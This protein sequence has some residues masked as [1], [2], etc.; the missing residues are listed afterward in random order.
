MLSEAQNT[1][2]PQDLTLLLE[3]WRAGNPSALEQLTPLVY[4]ELHQIAA[5]FLAG[6]RPAHVLQPTALINE[7]FLRLLSWHPDS[8]KSR[9]H[10]YGVSAQLMR[11]VLVQYA[12]HEKAEKRGGRA[13]L[14]T[15]SEAEL[16]TAALPDT[17]VDLEALDQ[18]LTDLEALDP[19]QSKIV[20]LRYFAGLTLEECA[21]QT[22]LS[23]S[24]VRRE[25]NFAR[26]W[27][28]KRLSS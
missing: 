22:N 4:N 2:N 19:R 14:I 9:S 26:A 13:L 7:A 18:A 8:W 21:E 5:R 12:R 20:E 16:P 24:T 28:L 3:S 6:E 23:V 17:N 1:Q 10:F 11:R 15:L 27:L 25:W